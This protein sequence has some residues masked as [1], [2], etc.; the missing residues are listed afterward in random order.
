MVESSGEPAGNEIPT[1]RPLKPPSN[2]AIRALLGPAWSRYRTALKGLAAMELTPEFYRYSSSGGWAVRFQIDHVTGCALYLANSLTGLVAVGA[3]TEA[4]LRA[5]P[6]RD[7]QKQ[8]LRLVLATPRRGSVRWVKMP[9]RGQEDVRRFLSLVETTLQLRHASPTS[10]NHTPPPQTTA[11][12]RGR[13][14]SDTPPRR[15]IAR[16]SSRG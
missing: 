3:R 14:R 6:R 7:E 12:A 11:A 9:L 1:H 2:A 15:S 4:A 13:K 16:R 10:L 5:N 8:I